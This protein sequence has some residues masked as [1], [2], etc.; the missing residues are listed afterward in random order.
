MIQTVMG[1][2]ALPF[3]LP[4]G[5]THQGGRPRPVALGD[6]IA[7]TAVWLV[8]GWKKKTAGIESNGGGRAA[9]LP[10]HPGPS[11]TGQHATQCDQA[12]PFKPPLGQTKTS[13]RPV[14]HVMVQSRSNLFLL[15]ARSFWFCQPPRQIPLSEFGA[16]PCPLSKGREGWL[17]RTIVA[18]NLWGKSKK[19]KKRRKIAN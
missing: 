10:R 12:M 13:F 4:F 19:K 8:R 15:A 17:E 11:S 3:F 5:E 18:G 16:G 1:S 9:C 6:I 14:L 2:T 7:P